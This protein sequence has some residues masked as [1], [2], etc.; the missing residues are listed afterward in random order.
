MPKVRALHQSTDIVLG[1][2]TALDT[3][4]MQI[5]SILQDKTGSDKILPC[6]VNLV[7]Y[8]VI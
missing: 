7:T 5:A 6:L 3:D 1:N 8:K 2:V 4:C